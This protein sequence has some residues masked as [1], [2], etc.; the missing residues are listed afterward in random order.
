[1][2]KTNYDGQELYIKD[3]AR[4]ND[5]NYQTLWNKFKET[6][7]ISKAVAISKEIQKAP[8]KYVDFF[9]EKMT[10]KQI[11]KSYG[12]DEFYLNDVYKLTANIDE[13]VSFCVGNVEK[14]GWVQKLE[15]QTKMQ[16]NTVNLDKFKY[17]EKSL[18][19]ETSLKSNNHTLLNNNIDQ[20]KLAE[21]KVFI[22]EMKQSMH[23]VLSQHEMKILSLRFGLEDG[24][25]R[26]LTE[27][28]H[29]L[30]LT[31]ERI[32]QIENRAIKKLRESKNIKHFDNYD[33]EI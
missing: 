20:I 29:I 16:K 17:L 5:I 14:Y 10:I 18:F 9:G 26:N 3:I 7:N 24:C 15:Q 23:Q 27:T 32:R 11:A 25:Y 21:N 28:G 31:K 12:I 6:G 30:G 33:Y 2:N 19:P 13:A 4:M 1:M 22:E 8:R